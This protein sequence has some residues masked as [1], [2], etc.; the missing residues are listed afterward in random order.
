MLL[1]TARTQIVPDVVRTG[2]GRR[3]LLKLTI[4]EAS[5]TY[6]G[7]GTHT[8]L[9]R[10][11]RERPVHVHGKNRAWEHTFPRIGGGLVRSGGLRSITNAH[12]YWNRTAE[13]M[14]RPG[15][16]WPRRGCFYGGGKLIW[17]EF[18]I[19]GFQWTTVADSWW[20]DS[21]LPYGVRGRVNL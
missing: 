5:L 13:S 3:R 1:T 10:T 7:L 11:P 6:D 17:G 8:N 14:I 21:L 20:L 4:Y 9:T 2:H 19:R 18:Q 16:G 15:S 12:R